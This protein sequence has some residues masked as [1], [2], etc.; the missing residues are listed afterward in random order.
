MT[1]TELFDGCVHEIAAAYAALGYKLGW[2]FLNVSRHVL[3]GPVKVAFITINPAGDHIPSDHPWPSCENG[4]SYLVERWDGY[5]AGKSKLQ[6]QVQGLFRMLKRYLAFSGSYQDLMAQSLISQ[7]IPFRSPAF[8]KL[9]NQGEALKF[10]R[11]I[12]MRLLPIALPKLIVCLGKEVQNELRTL[13]PSA[14][15]ATKSMTKSFALGWGNYTGEIDEYHTRA[16]LV[17]LLYLPHLSRFQ[18]FGNPKY[19]PYLDRIIAEL[20]RDV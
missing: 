6:V 8:D 2:R 5:P 18:M 17:R 15:G 19:I 20:C 11:R 9:P 3:D 7:F 12:W 14:M 10:G 4:V 16:G 1:S 13:M